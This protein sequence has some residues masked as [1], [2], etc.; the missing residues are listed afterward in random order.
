[1]AT[2]LLETINCPYCGGSQADPWGVERGFQAVRCRDCSLLYVNP[3]PRLDAIDRAVQTGAHGEEAGGLDVRAHRSQAKVA[4]YERLIG[5]LF[6]DVWV[7]GT[8]ISWLDVGAGY[9]EIVEAVS[10]LAPAGSDVQGI[11]PMAP[12]AKAARERGLNI[13]Q[14]YLRPGRKKVDFLS[15]IDVFS[16]VPDFRDFLASMRECLKPQG[17]IL[18]ETGNLADVDARRDF[19][20]ELGLPDHLVFAGEKHLRGYLTEAGFQVV[21]VEAIRVDDT[22]NL[23]KSIVKKMI[24]R[25]AQLR[26][27]YRSNYRQLVV[28]ARL[29]SH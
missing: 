9:G 25:P 26:L 3:R 12:K 15:N 28:R 1:M 23:A 14:G 22:L 5:K 19:P 11:E 29:E 16:H 13:E 6:E 27:P 21:R 2:D 17:E 10:R 7:K 8:P 4:R 18:I 20:F 24:G